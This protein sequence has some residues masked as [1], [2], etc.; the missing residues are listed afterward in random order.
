MVN[1][2]KLYI[3]VIISPYFILAKLSLFEVS[4]RVFLSKVYQYSLNIECVS[5]IVLGTLDIKNFSNMS[6]K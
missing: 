3:N 4:F 5:I 2:N 1:E 6:V